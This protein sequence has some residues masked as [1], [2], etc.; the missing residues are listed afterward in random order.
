MEVKG[1]LTCNF[2]PRDYSGDD[3]DIC[4]IDTD[5]IAKISMLYSCNQ[6]SFSGEDYRIDV[7]W[8]ALVNTVIESYNPESEYYTTI[9]G[10]KYKVLAKIQKECNEDDTWGVVRLPIALQF[11]DFANKQNAIFA[12]KKL[13]MDI[14]FV[15]NISVPGVLDL[16]S[17][18]L[19]I[20]S[21]DYEFKLSNFYFS[22]SLN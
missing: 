22:Q 19:T 8:S 10:Q 4:Q 3:A 17:S 2:K 5:V 12:L 15:A 1:V 6:L 9:E 16:Y 20:D 11:S 13:L 18:V 21:D 14:F 7:D